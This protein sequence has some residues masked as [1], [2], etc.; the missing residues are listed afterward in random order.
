MRI[1]RPNWTLRWLEPNS[2]LKQ[3]YRLSMPAR[4]PLQPLRIPIWT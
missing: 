1:S 4:R 2:N 3:T